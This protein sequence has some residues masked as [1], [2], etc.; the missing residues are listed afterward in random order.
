MDT[1][2]L[3]DQLD[4]LHRQLGELPVEDQ[5]KQALQTLVDEIEEEL[6]SEN[7]TA[8]HDSQSLEDRLNELMSDFEAEHPTTAGVIKDLIHRLAS[9]GV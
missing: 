7:E 9:I 4:S 5:R 1:Q 2:H 3:R 6:A 8:L